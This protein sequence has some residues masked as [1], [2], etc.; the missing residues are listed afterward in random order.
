MKNRHLTTNLAQLIVPPA[1]TTLTGWCWWKEKNLSIYTHSFIPHHLTTPLHNTTPT[2]ISHNRDT[3]GLQLSVLMVS[4]GNT[5][6]SAERESS[7]SLQLS[8]SYPFR[9]S[10]RL[11]KSILYLLYIAAK[12]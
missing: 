7:L 6:L 3:R 10:C 4:L 9:C 11:P 2:L 12:D 1:P 5:Q 8:E